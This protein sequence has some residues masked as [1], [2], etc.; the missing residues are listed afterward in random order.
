MKLAGFTVTCTLEEYADLKA[1]GQLYQ[2]GT[3][4]LYRGS[5]YAII[6]DK[7]DLLIH[8]QTWDRVRLGLP[9]LV[10][11]AIENTAYCE[12]DPNQSVITTVNRMLIIMDEYDNYFETSIFPFMEG[13]K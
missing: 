5:F 1:R 9:P 13:A 7:E 10:T 11:M 12:V 3:G 6:I 8:R 2:N 4:I